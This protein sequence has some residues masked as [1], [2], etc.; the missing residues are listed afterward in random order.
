VLARFVGHQW[1]VERDPVETAGVGLA[2]FV[3]HW[4]QVEEIP[5]KAVM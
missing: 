2:W 5:E 1:Q 3:G 4:L